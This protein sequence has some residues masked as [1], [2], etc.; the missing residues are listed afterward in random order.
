MNP[1]PSSRPAGST[2]FLA[3]VLCLGVGAVLFGLGLAPA[4]T[5]ALPFGIVLLV[6]GGAVWVPSYRLLKAAFVPDTDESRP[7]QLGLA[8]GGRPPSAVACPNCGGP[9]PLRL[10]EP[11]HSTCAHCGQRFALAPELARQ[12]TAAAAYLHAQSEAERHLTQGIEQLALREQGWLQRLK[13]TARILIAIAALAGLYG[14]FTRAGNDL[15]H[16]WAAFGLAAIGWVVFVT[17]QGARIV[18]NAIRTIVGRWTALQLPGVTGLSCRV[19]G[20]P[21]PDGQAAAVLRCGYCSADNLC[22]PEVLTQLM[23]SASHAAR[24]KLAFDQ[25]ARK[26]D[27]LAAFALLLM[28]ALTLLGWFALGAFAGSGFIRVGDLHLW[29]DPTAKF[30]VVRAERFGRV[31]TCVALAVAEGDRQRVVFDFEHLPAVSPEQLQA[32]S[33]VAPVSPSWLIGKNIE[34]KGEVRGVYRILRYPTRHLAQVG[35]SEYP[36][37]LPSD[38]NVL[39]GELTCLTNVSPDTGESI[40]M[41]AK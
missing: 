2:A 18:P 25:R 37:Y 14:F 9:A 12:L 22:G 4:T 32:A 13:K 20:G 23:A 3:A 19:C 15:W 16:C 1:M 5:E 41:T 39:G 8:A 36:H 40:D 38:F 17:R 34:G 29:N 26:G 30:V 7:G 27:A 21:L 24:G 11:T 31:Q 10:A 28:P 6:V 33:V 35:T